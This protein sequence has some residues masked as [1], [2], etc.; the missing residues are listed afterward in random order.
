MLEFYQ[1]SEDFQIYP[2]KGHRQAEYCSPFKLLGGPT[3]YSP[4]DEIEVRGEHP[5]SQ[6]DDEQG[7]GDAD[8]ARSV[9]EW[10]A[11]TEQQQDE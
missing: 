6:R 4:L 8:R 3:L 10:N 1:Q 11:H 7:E 9:D 2:N 5:C